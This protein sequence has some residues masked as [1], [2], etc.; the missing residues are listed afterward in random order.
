M[1]LFLAPLSVLA[2]I[3]IVLGYIWYAARRN[4]ITPAPCADDEVQAIYCSI[5]RATEYAQLDAIELLIKHFKR[6]RP[7]Y[8]QQAELM[9]ETLKLRQAA[10]GK[11]KIKQARKKQII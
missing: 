1:P 8:R 2:I 9:Q 6:R 5:E 10:I 11:E 3:A 7:F 4:R